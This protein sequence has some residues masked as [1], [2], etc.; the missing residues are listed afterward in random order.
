MKENWFPIG[1]WNYVDCGKLKPSKEVKLWKELGMTLAM[2]FE[3]RKKQDRACMI[4]TLDACKREGLRVIVCDFRTH[5]KNYEEK[6]ESAFI[7]DVKEAVEDFGGHKAFYAFHVGDEP[8]KEHWQSMKRACEIVSRFSV[9]FVN[10]YP[11]WE[12]ED[13]EEKVGVDFRKYG[14]RLAE[15]LRE[16]GLKNLAYDCYNQCY[17]YEREKGL[18][19]FFANLNLFQKTAAECKVPM[20]TS[21][22]SVGH[23]CY[24]VPTEDDFRWQIS[25]SIAHGA[26][27]LLWFFIYERTLDSSYRLPPVDL[28]E[29]RTE[30]F[31]RLARQNKIF[32]DY[33][34]SR[35]AQAELEKVEHFNK[36]YGKTPLYKAGDFADFEIFTKYDSPLI[37]SEF[38]D[39]AGKFLLVVNNSQS[40][41]ERIK[42]ALEGSPFDEWLAPGQMKVLERVKK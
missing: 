16:T 17:E 7:A 18:E 30:T 40:G 32:R 25:A 10:F 37:I 14:D 19:S 41:S 21:L 5:W 8:D 2:S 1:F 26:K 15:T 33:F 4:K 42:G 29:R 20:W 31:E 27:G 34:S 9:P 12:G 3:Y 24:R 13:F 35:F 6:G 22:L 39:A 23:W 11:V 36:A 38:C 28:Y